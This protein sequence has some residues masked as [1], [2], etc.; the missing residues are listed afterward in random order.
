MYFVCAPIC[1]IRSYMQLNFAAMQAHQNRK[2]KLKL[3]FLCIG[4]LVT[5]SC[6]TINGWGQ[7]R[8]LEATPKVWL[9]VGMAQRAV[10]SN[11]QS[12][13]L[14]ETIWFS[15][16]LQMSVP[17]FFSLC[18]PEAVKNAEKRIQPQKRG[19]QKDDVARNLTAVNFPTAKRE[20]ET[21]RLCPP[22][23]TKENKWWN[24]LIS[25]RFVLPPRLQMKHQWRP[26][27]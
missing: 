24:W 6:S 9:P 8:K 17:K 7:E 16:N 27:L 18:T 21:D 22:L 3:K 5:E 4:G 23:C 15:L 2:W 14:S 25:N 26:T 1:V 13:H 19:D 20:K 11:V 12:G 10:V